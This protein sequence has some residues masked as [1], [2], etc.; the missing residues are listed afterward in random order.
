MHKEYLPTHKH[1]NFFILISTSPKNPLVNHC[2]FL[3]FSHVFQKGKVLL[4]TTPK[5]SAI[6]D[7]AH[8]QKKRHEEKLL[9]Q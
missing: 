5:T 2:L 8:I 7:Y 3:H 4:K 1:R 9:P 6:S